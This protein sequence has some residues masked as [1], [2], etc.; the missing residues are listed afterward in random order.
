MGSLT[1]IVNETHSFP[2]HLPRSNF[3]SGL[4][5]HDRFIWLEKS[6]QLVRQFNIQYHSITKSGVDGIFFIT[7]LGYI[8]ALGL[9]TVIQILGLGSHKDISIPGSP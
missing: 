2:L 9:G 6:L 4:F 3:D 5:V 1:A 7:V 8:R